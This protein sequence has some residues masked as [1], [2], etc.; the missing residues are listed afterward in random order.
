VRYARL[1][2]SVRD[3]R[4]GIEC[5]HSVSAYLVSIVEPIVIVRGEIGVL[6]VLVGI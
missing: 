5:M 6:D 3:A 2:R 1:E 4:R